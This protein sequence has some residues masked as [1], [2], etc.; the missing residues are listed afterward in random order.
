MNSA[1][2]IVDAGRCRWTVAGLGE[3]PMRSAYH[4]SSNETPGAA[5]RRSTAFILTVIAHVLI[6]LLVLRLGPSLPTSP[7]GQRNPTTFQML[8]DRGAPSPEQS[9]P[10]AAEAKP[11]SRGQREKPPT[12]PRVSPPIKSV[13]AS[14]PGKLTLGIDLLGGD[15]LFK[16]ADVAKLARHPE[17]RLAKV[18]DEKPLK[19]KTKSAA[20]YGPGSGPD[21]GPIYEMVAWYREPTD[22]EMDGYL[23]HQPAGSWGIIA[24]KTAPDYRVENCR[25]VS[26]SPV[27]SGI[28]R[29]MRQA[30]W[31]FRILPPKEDG[32]P[33]IGVW[34]QVRMTYTRNG[35]R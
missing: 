24:C 31:Q 16:A 15:E 14:P 2:K 34:M 29:A 30:A 23:S 19:P 7:N 3:L 27:G 1:K 12:P 35:L 13:P 22:A 17:D 33:L 10:A 6:L 26:E 9:S 5:R 32:K 20:V 11:A 21:G 8:P 4:P 18:E 28:A 25:T